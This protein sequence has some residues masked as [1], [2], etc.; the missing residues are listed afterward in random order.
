MQK[1]IVLIIVGAIVVI[2]LLC[3]IFNMPR[4]E[5]MEQIPYLR[6]N[7]GPNHCYNRGQFKRCVRFGTPCRMSLTG[8]WGEISGRECRCTPTKA[9]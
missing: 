8:N 6:R 7:C 3:S 2:L 9:M 4:H 5:G 1:N